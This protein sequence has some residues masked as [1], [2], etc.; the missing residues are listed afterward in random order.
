[1]RRWHH[2]VGLLGVLLLA[3]GCGL[4]LLNAPAEAHMGDVS[5]ILYVHVP[6][7]WITLVAYT[8]A[9]GFAVASLWTSKPRWDDRLTGAIETGVVLNTCL[10]ASGMLFARPTWGIWWDW[11]VRLT[12]SL[13]ALIL[14][15]GI[16]GLR[17]F[18]DDAERRAMWSSVATIVAYVDIPM[19]YFCVKWWRSI[20]QTQSSPSTVDSAMVLPWRINAFA[21]LFIAI[22]L[23][24]GRAT[25]EAR[26]R[27]L[28]E[29]SEPEPLSVS[30]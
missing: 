18:V 3:L 2:A 23:I 14:F 4:G 12:T 25:I 16:L 22:W 10:L 15:G 26:R 13:L 5:R 30:A 17:A 28:A 24:A 1:M 21:I 19:I 9:L 7:A 29:S 11:D 8:F 20:H 6:S 27:A